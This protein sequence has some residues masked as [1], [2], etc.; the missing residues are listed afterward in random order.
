M[1]IKTPGDFVLGL[2]D[3]RIYCADASNIAVISRDGY[4]LEEVSF[5]WGDEEIIESRA[6]KVFSIKGFRSPTVYRGKVFSL[7]SGGR[8]QILFLSLA[9]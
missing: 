1:H 9:I 5:Q 7:L 8:S 6:N 4:V 3:G 2:K